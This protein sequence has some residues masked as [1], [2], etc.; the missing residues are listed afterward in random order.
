M[1]EVA[2]IHVNRFAAINEMDAERPN[3]KQLAEKHALV[4]RAGEDITKV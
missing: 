1:L 2:K 3:G 4:D